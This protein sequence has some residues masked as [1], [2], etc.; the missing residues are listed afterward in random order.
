MPRPRKSEL[1]HCVHFKWRMI[2]RAGV[3]WAD[4][5]SNVPDA[6]RHSL[7]TRDRKE[8]LQVLPELDLRRAEDLGLVPVSERSD[9]ETSPLPLGEGRSLYESHLARPQVTGG[10]RKSTQKRYRTVFDKFVP[11]AA[12]HNVEVWNR[13]NTQ[14]L[15][16]YAAHLKQQ[17]YADKTVKNELTTL[18]QAVRWLISA[19]HLRGMKPIVLA[20]RRVESEPAYCYRPT[21]IQAMVRHTAARKDLRWLHDVIVTLACTGLRIGELC[22]LRWTDLDLSSGQLTLTDET[23]PRGGSDLQSREL[24]GR[25]SRSFPIH[26]DLA[27]VLENRPPEG[28]YVF[29]GPRGGRL[30]ADTVRR[31]FIREVIEPLQ[32]QFPTSEGSRGFE[33]GRLHSFR[34]AF[35]SRCANSNV[36]DRMVM[37]WL[38]H[39]DSAMIR[40]Y[41]HLHDEEARRR[42]N[43]LDFLGGAG[44]CSASA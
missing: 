36:P 37:Q 11:F 32:E 4:G 43:Q 17:S 20:M 31:V 18:K 14:L 24:K 7:G 25:R 27:T 38:G 2:Q 26:S 10:T 42:M 35:C 8:A 21:E 41:Y 22:S 1:I 23:A 39:Q 29:Y 33:H 15:H 5:R 44:G 16:A 34:H 12:N 28:P 13:V 30:K 6:G 40:H 3:W 19:G 9:A